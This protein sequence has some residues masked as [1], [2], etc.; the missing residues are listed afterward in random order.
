MWT[1]VVFAGILPEETR[2]G[3]EKMRESGINSAKPKHRERRDP[4]T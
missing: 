4:T 1:G 2:T 3:Q